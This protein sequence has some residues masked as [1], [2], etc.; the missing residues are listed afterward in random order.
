[1]NY[2]VKETYRWFLKGWVLTRYNGKLEW[3]KDGISILINP[4]GF[5]IPYIIY[6]LR[7][8]YVS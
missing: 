3:Y 4:Y 6:P 8:T 2:N 7:N 5:L 1:M